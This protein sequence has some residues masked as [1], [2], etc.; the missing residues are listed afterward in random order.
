VN[1]TAVE[2][3]A[4]RDP[5][6]EGA[7]NFRDLGGC[8]TR[9]G[10]VIRPGK[11]FRSN[12]LHELTESDFT[13]FEALGVKL[14]CDLR[15]PIEREEAPN[16]WRARHGIAELHV[17]TSAKLKNA[18]LGLLRQLRDNPTPGRAVELLSDIYRRMP[19]AFDGLLAQ[20]FDHIL[21]DGG[22][23]VVIHCSAGKDRTGFVC[24][25]LMAALDVPT[26]TIFHDYMQ[27]GLPGRNKAIRRSATELM[28][29][30]FGFPPAPEVLDVLIGVREDYLQLALDTVAAEYGSINAYLESAGGLD[31]PKR[32]RL[33]QLLLQ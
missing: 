7:D 27:S 15:G 14:I 8:K 5:A 4:N 3:H 1:V 30:I 32:L 22:L 24:A 18:N 33:K 12:T 23:P 13:H 26:E 9:D 10:A 28:N 19:A 29:E 11:V 25:M 31:A 16:L 21:G 6:L 2:S 20:L 17:D